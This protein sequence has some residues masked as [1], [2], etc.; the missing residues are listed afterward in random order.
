MKKTI[1]ST[2]SDYVMTSDKSSIDL[3]D[4][5]DVEQGILNYMLLSNDNFFYI[6][7]KLLRDDFIFLVYG[8]IFKYLIRCEDIFTSEKYM[9]DN[10]SDY[11]ELLD[12]CDNSL[13]EMEFKIYTFA[14]ILHKE[15]EIDT[16]FVEYTLSQSASVDIKKDFEILNAVS[17]QRNISSKSKYMGRFLTIETEGSI[18]KVTY[19]D[20]RIVKLVSTDVKNLPTKLYSSFNDTMN[21]LLALDYESGD[22]NI[23]LEFYKGEENIDNISIAYIK[24]DLL[25]LEWFDNICHWANKHEI[26]KRTF[27]RER[28]ALKKTIMFH[29]SNLGIKELPKEMEE[30]SVVVLDLGDNHFTIFPDVIYKF[31]KLFCFSIENNQIS[32]ISEEIISLQILKEL[33]VSNN[34]LKNLPDNLFKLKN[35]AELNLAGNQLTEIPDTISNLSELHTLSISNNN[36]SMLPN[37]IALL[38]NLQVLNI[39][40]NLIEDIPIDIFK[41]CRLMELTIDD[42]LLPLVAQNIQNI[43][44]LNFQTINLTASYLEASSSIIKDLNLSIDTK[45]W[46]KQEDKRD[47]GCILLSI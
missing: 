33:N 13:T 41:S 24:K 7:D 6:K 46:I 30:L 19:I 26:D 20:D 10:S 42:A 8:T 32:H 35:L 3:C 11:Y 27:S 40:N 37:S 28:F 34:R 5:R 14:E 39:E 17:S 22:N 36:I 43:K 29:L 44:Y 23:S 31:K 9:Q 21:T 2:V 16:E 45:P 4:L 47:N 12:M 18:T 1:L 25:K 15:M 38:E